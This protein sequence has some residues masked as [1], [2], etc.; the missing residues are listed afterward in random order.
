MGKW[1]AVQTELLDSHKVRTAAKRLKCPK[2]LVVGILCTLWAW[3]MDNAD[4][5]GRLKGD[6][7]RDDI[8]SLFA[9][10]AAE[11]GLDPQKIADT[12][13][14]C[15]LLDED[16]SEIFIHDWHEYQSE[17]YRA[18]RRKEHDADR[19]RKSR[20][21]KPKKENALDI[22]V[23]ESVLPAAEPVQMSLTPATAQKG[24]RTQRE[25]VMEAWS[26][27]V[28]YGVKNVITIHDGSKRATDLR[29]RLTQYGLPKVLEAI[30]R[31]KQ[32]DYLVGK[33]KYGWVITFDWFVLPSNFPKV[34]DGNYDRKNAQEDADAFERLYAQ[35]TKEAGR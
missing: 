23:D 34:L 1:F 16:G 11:A 24:K 12:M 6:T 20:A 9:P 5:D 33:N 29:A 14:E 21:L 32:S 8:A 10:C 18:K 30:E 25:I 2:C 3:G 26:A 19:K 7:D 22:I 13:F 15:G 28:P 35:Y 4:E 17:W 27:L 31:I